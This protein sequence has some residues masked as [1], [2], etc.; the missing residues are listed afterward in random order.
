MLGA[1]LGQSY[2]AVRHGGDG[3]GILDSVPG[4]SKGCSGYMTT[5][6]MEI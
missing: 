3:D 4:W 5:M 6:K 2:S 1:G